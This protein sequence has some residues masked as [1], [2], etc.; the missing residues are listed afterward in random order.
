MAFAI[1]LDPNRKVSRDSILPD[2]QPWSEDHKEEMIFNHTGGAEPVPD[3]HS[4]KTEEGLL[5]R[6]A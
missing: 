5:K 6:C 3:I 1:S 4:A 2:W